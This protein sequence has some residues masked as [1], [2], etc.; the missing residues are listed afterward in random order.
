MM[1]S[2]E[3]G[4][5]PGGEDDRPTMGLPFNALNSDVD[6]AGKFNGSMMPEILAEPVEMP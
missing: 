6:M 1:R 3:P 5:P 4:A 2:A